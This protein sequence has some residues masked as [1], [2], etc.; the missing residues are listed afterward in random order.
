MGLFAYILKITKTNV[1]KDISIL[2][3]G[4]TLAQLIGV[5]ISPILS[6][7]YSPNDFGVVGSL[8]AFTGIVS[9][10][11]ALKYDLAII[12]ERDNKKSKALLDLNIIIIVLV[13][14]ITSVGLFTSPYWLSYLDDKKELTALLPYGAIVIFF[15]ALFNTYYNRLNRDKDYKKMAI[16]QIIRR[17]TISLTQVIV[18]LFF[19]SAF[20]LLLGNILGVVIPVLLLF[21][22]KKSFSIYNH[23]SFLELRSIAKKYYKFALYTTPQSFINLLSAQ[24]P[25]FVFGY[26]FSIEI[27][28]VYFFTL[29]I[30]QVPA[31]F[32]GLSFRQVFYQKAAQMREDL[33]GLKILYLK[34][35]A[36]LG[37]IMIIPMLLFFLFG[38]SLFVILFGKE[39]ALAGVFAGWMFLWYGSN[40]IA[41]PARSLYLVFEMQKRVFVLDS[42]LF[43]FRL[44]SLILLSKYY[45]SEIVIKW[46]SVFSLFFN[47]IVI[48]W[49]LNFFRIKLIS[50]K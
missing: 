27:V 34:F 6:R 47:L 46:F 10:L 44:V 29:K 19:A 31:T 22:T 32:I 28:G 18:G 40:V 20:G 11:G 41:G 37:S 26:F 12:I 33:N 25:I 50:N 17:T 2:A 14:I 1:F 48:I 8:L 3:G 15:S 24:M 39:W 35:T 42:I 7:L 16:S 49:W 21:V 9:L 38:E 4:N 36:L 43:I 5:L 45:A 13:T 23:S 30:V